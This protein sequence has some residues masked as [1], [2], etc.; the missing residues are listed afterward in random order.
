M[1]IISGWAKGRKLHSPPGQSN[2]IRPTTDRAREALFSIISASLAQA[3]ILD[4]CAGT[5]ALGLEALSRGAASAIFMDNDRQSITI[6]KKNISSCLQSYQSRTSPDVAAPA[7]EVINCD[8][9]RGIK[10]PDRKSP[11]PRLFDLIFLDP[12]YS[13]GLSLQLL[14]EIDTKPLLA[15]EGLVVV[16]ERAKEELPE[17]LT[18]LSLRDTR[19][20]GDTGFWF[21]RHIQ[22][23]AKI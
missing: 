3:H 12:P 14:R 16:E 19:R 7:I 23:Q 8:L 13:T 10:L 4:L 1:R 21:Y 9:R 22:E 17:T 2:H 15:P 20:Y 11:H 5:G 6:I 18:T